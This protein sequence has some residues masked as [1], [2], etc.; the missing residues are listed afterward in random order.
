M[1][2]LSPSKNLTLCVPFSRRHDI[3]TALSAK[4]E[5]MDEA[6]SIEFYK[7]REQ[8][9]RSL[10]DAADDPAI[11]AIHLDMAARYAALGEASP[12]PQRK[13]LGIRSA[14]I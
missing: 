2:S 13:K 6:T 11:R 1:V 4:D 9:E 3:G 14:R 7:A 12:E 8:Q 5:A 10:A